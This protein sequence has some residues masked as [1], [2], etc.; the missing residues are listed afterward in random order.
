MAANTFWATDRPWRLRPVPW[1]QLQSFKLADPPG[2]RLSTAVV[3][4]CLRKLCGSD[5][6]IEPRSS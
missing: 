4:L 1:I 3:P 6:V 2:W 5:S